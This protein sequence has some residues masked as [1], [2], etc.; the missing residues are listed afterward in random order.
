[1][2]SVNISEAV[3]GTVV[4]VIRRTNYGQ[5]VAFALEADLGINFLR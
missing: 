4:F 2:A 5:Y 3:L 1:V